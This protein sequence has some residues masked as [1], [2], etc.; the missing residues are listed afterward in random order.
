MT[1]PYYQDKQITIYLGDCAEVMPE[2]G[3][4]DLL[5]TD[6]PYG[7]NRDGQAGDLIGAAGA[8]KAHEFGGWDAKPPNAAVFKEMFISSCNQI[9]WGANYFVD[10][11]PVARGWLVWNK[12]QRILQSDGELAYTSFDIPLRICDMSRGELNADG[13]QHPTQKP[14]SLMKW[15]IALGCLNKRAISILDPFCGS[16]STLVAAKEMGH[17]ATGIEISERYAEIAAKRLSQNQLELA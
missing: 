14:V 11:L 17:R 15:C 12:I 1:Q 13:T 9:I 3:I 2:L 16:G 7:I 6:P 4:Y 8:R 10:R 5:L